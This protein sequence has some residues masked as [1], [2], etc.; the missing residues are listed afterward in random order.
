MFK[1]HRFNHS[2]TAFVAPC[3]WFI[4]KSTPPC[5]LKECPNLWNTSMAKPAL[6]IDAQ[7]PGS[8]VN[9]GHTLSPQR[10]LSKQSRK[11]GNMTEERRVRWQTRLKEKERKKGMT[12]RGTSEA[13]ECS[14]ARIL[15]V[16]SAH[17]HILVALTLFCLL[18]KGGFPGRKQ[19]LF[20]WCDSLSQHLLSLPF[21]VCGLNDL[22]VLD[23][24][25]AWVSKEQCI[26]NLTFTTTF[27]YF[28]RLCEERYPK[29]AAYYN[30]L[31]ERPSIKAS[32]PPTWLESPQGQ[33]LLKDL[34]DANTLK[35]F[36]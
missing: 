28:G 8:W 1:I 14:A 10:G 19:L 20:G 16:G 24:M 34:W 18:G 15:V 33:D 22:N 29:L 2:G 3:Q 31:K 17:R 25:N 7:M 32:W 13:N 23:K 26:R 36:L 5:L 27:L 9:V 6:A 11:K 4:I 30:R 12:W 35:L 21:R